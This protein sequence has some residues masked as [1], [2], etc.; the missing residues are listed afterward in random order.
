[1]R[2]AFDTVAI[3]TALLIFAVGVGISWRQ[4]DWEN[5]VV[6]G[7]VSIGILFQ[8]IR[9]RK[10]VHTSTSLAARESY[11]EAVASE[12][13]YSRSW[14]RSFIFSFC[15]CVLLLLALILIQVLT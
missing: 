12:L 10:R 4:S 15:L 3:L 13:K 6:P 14:K 9:F 2:Y 8:W 11:R 1:M 5:L 7:I